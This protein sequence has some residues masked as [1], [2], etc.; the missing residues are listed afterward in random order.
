M[1]SGAALAE[2]SPSTAQSTRKLKLWRKSPS[3]YRDAF[4]SRRCLIP[5]DGWYEWRQ[6][7]SGKQP[8][9]I[10][11]GGEAFAFAGLWERWQNGDTLD[12]YTIITG[13]AAESVS[14]I[15]P[16]MPLVFPPAAWREW[17]SADTPRSARQDMLNSPQN[18]FKS[19]PI[20]T[21]V[22]SPGTRDRI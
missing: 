12:S 19:Y 10:H 11:Q 5:A 8:Y 21:R 13:P 7:E 17:L 2:R 16:R 4:K 15:H 22:N 9:Y 18:D 6:G 20:S 14:H 3:I 1:G